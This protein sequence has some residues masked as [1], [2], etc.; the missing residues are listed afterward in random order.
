MMDDE[1]WATALLADA[2]KEESSTSTF[3]I[4]AAAGAASAAGLLVAH[5]RYSKNDE[6]FMRA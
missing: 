5:K 1:M 3:F 6:D 4:A 2:P